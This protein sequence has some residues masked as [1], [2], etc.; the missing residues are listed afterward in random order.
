ML[1]DAMLTYK[2]SLSRTVLLSKTINPK[3]VGKKIFFQEKVKIFKNKTL[4]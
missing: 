2:V 1:W 3:E 4:N